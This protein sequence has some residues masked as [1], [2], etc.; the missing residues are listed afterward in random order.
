M[1]KRQRSLFSYGF[2]ERSLQ[3]AS[4]RVR[5]PEGSTQSQAS[6]TPEEESCYQDP[7]GDQSSSTDI[8][9]YSE[10]EIVH[11]T[12]EQKYWIQNHAFRPGLNFKFPSKV[13]YSKTR[14][15]QHSWL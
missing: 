4:K 1:T 15:F 13:E 3:T 7:A 5:S 10:T 12:N 9:K 11:F 8:G 6:C 14:S 2:V